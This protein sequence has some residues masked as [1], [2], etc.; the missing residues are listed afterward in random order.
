M[1]YKPELMAER[2]AVLG[3]FIEAHPN[4]TYSPVVKAALMNVDRLQGGRRL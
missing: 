4:G 2:A 3:P 1:T